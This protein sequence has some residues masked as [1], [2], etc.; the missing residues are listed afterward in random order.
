M[1]NVRSRMSNRKLSTDAQPL[2]ELVAQTFDRRY[3]IGKN[4][5]L[6]RT[7]SDRYNWTTDKAFLRTFAM[8]LQRKGVTNYDGQRITVTLGALAKGQKLAD[9][10]PGKMVR[11]RIGTSQYSGKEVVRAYPISYT[12]YDRNGDVLVRAGYTLGTRLTAENAIGPDHAELAAVFV[13]R[14]NDPDFRTLLEERVKQPEAEKRRKKVRE[15]FEDPVERMPESYRSILAQH[16]VSPSIIRQQKLLQHGE[17]IVNER[18]SAILLAFDPGRNA[19]NWLRSKLEK[20]ELPADVVE[21][22]AFIHQFP[23]QREEVEKRLKIIGDYQLQWKPEGRKLIAGNLAEELRWLATSRKTEAKYARELYR[24]L[25]KK[26]VNLDADHAPARFY[27]GDL[28][29]H[30]AK[31]CKLLLEPAWTV[32]DRAGL[33]RQFPIIEFREEWNRELVGE[34]FGSIRDFTKAVEGLHGALESKA[35]PKGE[36]PFVQH[37][38]NRMSLGEPGGKPAADNFLRRTRIDLA[39]KEIDKLKVLHKQYVA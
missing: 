10:I 18:W 35:I 21:A 23:D 8:A 3:T 33:E 37:V 6:W 38:L 1:G 5:E 4:I 19:Y 9:P 14:L 17:H 31:V 13:P 26:D 32:G 29:P 12:V 24:S 7:F 27:H 16:N 22:W 34:Y 11:G 2:D 28:P 30:P 25:Y 36:V 20:G 15:L 39:E